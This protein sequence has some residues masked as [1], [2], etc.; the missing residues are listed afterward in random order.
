MRVLDL[1]SIRSYD[2]EGEGD[3]SMLGRNWRD[4]L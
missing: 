2:P 3:E 1:T 4:F